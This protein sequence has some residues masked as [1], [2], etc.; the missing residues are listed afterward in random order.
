MTKIEKFTK[1]YCEQ[2]K[3]FGL[4]VNKN[5]FITGIIFGFFSA[6]LGAF[7]SKGETLGYIGFFL[8]ALLDFVLRKQYQNELEKFKQGRSVWN[9]E[10][11]N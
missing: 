4:I 10:I 5:W 2:N 9:L 11:D 1:I 7:V 6:I 3:L 8:G